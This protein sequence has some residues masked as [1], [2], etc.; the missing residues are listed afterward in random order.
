MIND[1]VNARDS[2]YHAN[3]RHGIITGIRRFVIFDNIANVLKTKFAATNR[4]VIANIN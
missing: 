4:Y 1:L 3:R 2:S